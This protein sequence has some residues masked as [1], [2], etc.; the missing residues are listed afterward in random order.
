LSKEGDEGE[1]EQIPVREQPLEIEENSSDP[2]P[3]S[4]RL[5]INLNRLSGIRDS[6][7]TNS[8]LDS[9]KAYRP[10]ERAKSDYP[11]S[12]EDSNPEKLNTKI[13]SLATLIRNHDI[14]NYTYSLNRD[15]T[16][17]V[18]LTDSLSNLFGSLENF[19]EK[20]SDRLSVESLTKIAD[21]SLKFSTSISCL[22]SHREDEFK[23]KL[24]L[25][26]KHLTN[27]NQRSS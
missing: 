22:D 26:F 7:R 12:F 2:T 8:D 9:F 3:A 1:E 21:K 13:Y 15:A 10:E 24:R 25:R 18:N 27:L 17:S 6:A 23:G 14:V 11:G 20:I 16:I 5:N 19:F 4:Q